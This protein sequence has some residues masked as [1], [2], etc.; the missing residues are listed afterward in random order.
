M[1]R[2]RK[3]KSPSVAELLDGVQGVSGGPYILLE[4]FPPQ[5]VFETVIHVTVSPDGSVKLTE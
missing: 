4:C 5:P 1:S 3:R 2:P